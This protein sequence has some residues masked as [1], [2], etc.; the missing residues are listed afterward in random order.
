MAALALAAGC[1]GSGAKAVVAPDAAQAL[2]VYRGQAWDERGRR[3]KFR[4]LLHARPP[5]RI[6][7]EMIPPVGGPAWILDAGDGR[8]SLTLVAD[9]TAYVGAA[10]AD[11]VERLLGVA[12]APDAFVRALLEGEP[13][14]PDLRF[15][16][17]PV[18]GHGLP[19]TFEIDRGGRGFRLERTDI[20]AVAAG[21]LG[22]GRPPAGMTE[23]PVEDL[24]VEP[25]YE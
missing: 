22:T 21:A 25:G 20:R 2:G 14:G 11:V 24:A 18:G 4:L 15:S 8:L 1:A 19:E 7:A 17:S 16:R 9:A 6:H 10:R 5:D 23:V 3:T 12:V 13:P